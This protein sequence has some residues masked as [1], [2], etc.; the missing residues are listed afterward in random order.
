MKHKIITIALLIAFILGFSSCTEMDMEAQASYAAASDYS[1]TTYHHRGDH[2]IY[3]HPRA[4]H[5]HPYHHAHPHHHHCDYHCDHY[6]HHHDHGKHKHDEPK[7]KH[8]HQKIWR[9]LD[10][11][12]EALNSEPS[13]YY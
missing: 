9:V 4:C 3:Y 6:C 13:Y 11:I 8:G 10:E 2:D 7:K 5:P 1:S 12:D